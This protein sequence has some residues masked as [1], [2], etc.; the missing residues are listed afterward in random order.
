M[1]GWLFIVSQLSSVSITISIRMA[2]QWWSAK[3]RIRDCKWKRT[4]D[5]IGEPR[6]SL[7]ALSFHFERSSP[8]MNWSM[9]LVLIW[10]FQWRRRQQQRR[11]HDEC[12][13]VVRRIPQHRCSSQAKHR[14]HVR[15]AIGRNRAVHH[16]IINIPSK[17]MFKPL[18]ISMAEVRNWNA[19]VIERV[20]VHCRPS[21]RLFFAVD[22]LLSNAISQ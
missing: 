17:E 5:R 12:R 11:Q 7:L 19:R 6:V 15:E 3:Q 21:P 13:V 18:V 20:L 4:G 16:S 14:S 10:L 2:T 22:F 1:N 8:L 9:V